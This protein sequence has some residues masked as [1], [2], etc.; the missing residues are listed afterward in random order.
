ML[1]N[2]TRT[3]EGKEWKPAMIKKHSNN[4][5]TLYYNS[6]HGFAN[7]PREARVRFFEFWKRRSHRAGVP[8]SRNATATAGSTEP[9]AAA[10]A[11][12]AAADTG[13]TVEVLIAAPRQKPWVNTEQ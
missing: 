10:V 7:K 5:N 6:A 1:L 2:R 3:D 8:A 11:A 4:K 9:A 12:A 13:E